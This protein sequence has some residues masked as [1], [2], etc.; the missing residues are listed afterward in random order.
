MAEA[1]GSLLAEMG[2][3]EQ[4]IS[5]LRKVVA[6][7]PEEGHEKYLYLGQL[8]EGDEAVAM[9][10]KGVDLLQLL[11][12]QAQAEAAGSAGGE[13]G[14]SGRQKTEKR[15][16][17]DDDEDE[18]ADEDMAGVEKGEVGEEEEEEDG[19]PTVE[20]LSQ[21]LCA[22]LCSLAEMVMGQAEDGLEAGGTACTEVWERAGAT[23]CFNCG[24]HAPFS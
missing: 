2:E 1:Y 18:E 13:G 21:G 11:L 19:P 7:S 10:R 23:V 6:L 22:A 15:G 17:D 24:D 3:E 20:E 14:I 12:D 16:G 8:L 9:T 4:A 5:V